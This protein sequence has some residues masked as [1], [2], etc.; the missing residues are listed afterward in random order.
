MYI[1]K[2]PLFKTSII[3]IASIIFT[4]LYLYT[5]VVRKLEL[6]DACS[7]L[8]QDYTFTVL[9]FKESLPSFNFIYN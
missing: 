3:M 6:Y 4:Y 8:P 1:K 7:K 5:W 9:N 2:W